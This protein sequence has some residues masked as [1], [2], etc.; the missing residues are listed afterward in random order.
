MGALEHFYMRDIRLYFS[1]LTPLINAITLK[2]G[3]FVNQGQ[4]WHVV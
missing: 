1:F 4:L 2:V 3:S